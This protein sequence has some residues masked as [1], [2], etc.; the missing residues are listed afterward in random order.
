MV[1]L[2]HVADRLGRS[3]DLLGDLFYRSLNQFFTNRLEFG[4]G[5]SS[6]V[7]PSF[8]PV[9]D[10]QAPAGLLAAPGVAL[11]AHD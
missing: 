3:I 1:S 11:E 8:D 4:F 5:P 7:L 6:M 10:D 2:E 9:L